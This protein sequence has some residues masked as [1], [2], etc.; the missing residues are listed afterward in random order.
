AAGPAGGA[1]MLA[2]DEGLTVADDLKEKGVDL[3]T[4]TKVAAVAGVAAGA[5]VA[6]PLAG[7]SIKATLGLYA[8]G[9]PGAF[10]AQQAAT[11]EILNQ[12]NYRDLAVQYDPLDPT[13]LA[14]SSLIP[15]PFAALGVRA[16]I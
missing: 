15:A 5:G 16:N 3:A 13:G 4:R 1:V 6:M 14:L 12:A 10:V 11:R 9:G 7:P 2:G 8:L